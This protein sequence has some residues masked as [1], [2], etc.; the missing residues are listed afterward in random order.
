VCV[1]V[2]GWEELQLERV[3]SRQPCRGVVIAAVLAAAFS[4]TGSLVWGVVG[5]GLRVTEH[6][7]VAC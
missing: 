4:R 2:C 7:K 1:C 5:G 3:V 6:R